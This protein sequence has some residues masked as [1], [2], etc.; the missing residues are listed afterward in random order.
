[1]HLL[2]A[3]ML[4]LSTISSMDSSKKKDDFNLRIKDPVETAIQVQAEFNRLLVAADK[5][6]PDI[7]VAEEFLEL[8]TL[9]ASS[10][11]RIQ[12]IQ[13]TFESRVQKQVAEK[14]PTLEAT[15]KKH[16]EFIRAIDKVT[17]SLKELEKLLELK[18]KKSDGVMDRAMR[19]IKK[20]Q[21]NSN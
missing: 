12:F 8:N 3:T 5:A 14:S 16:T 4:A 21:E 19:I 7:D 10:L 11:D 6:L 17:S 9:L 15:K 2:I 13:Q 20:I 18:P 1:M